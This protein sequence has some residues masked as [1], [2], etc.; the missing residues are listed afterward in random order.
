MHFVR[1]TFEILDGIPRDSQ[2]DMYRSIYIEWFW[3]R[4]VPIWHS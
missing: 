3:K 1:G 4:M 2:T